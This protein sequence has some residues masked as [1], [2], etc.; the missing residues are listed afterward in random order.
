MI[1]KHKISVVGNNDFRKRPRILIVRWYIRLRQ[2][3][4][5]HIDVPVRDADAI[6]RYA[7]DALYKALARVA[8]VA[9]NDNIA[10]FNA[11]KAVN[12]L[13]DEDPLLVF[14]SRLHAAAFNFYWL[15]QK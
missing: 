3:L 8:R 13:V 10:A 11:L 1:A 4:T 2:F 14:Q 5:I 6:A 15:I 9:E 12:Q 7:D